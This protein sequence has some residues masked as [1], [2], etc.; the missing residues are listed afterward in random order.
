M[1][2]GYNAV[3]NCEYYFLDDH[4]L[5][6][7]YGS[8]DIDWG[9][10]NAAGNKVGTIGA[11]AAGTFNGILGGLSGSLLG[12]AGTSLGI[13]GGVIQGMFSGYVIGYITGAATEIWNQKEGD[14]AR[15]TGK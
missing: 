3:N 7:I 6:Q 4:E 13:A 14:N 9:K 8:G 1:L 2:K 12:P 10:V 15:Q 5:N 11:V